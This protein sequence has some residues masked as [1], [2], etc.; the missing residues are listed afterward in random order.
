MLQ[1][2]QVFHPEQDRIVSVRECA[3]AQVKFSHHV[4][5]AALL[6]PFFSGECN[7][8]RWLIGAR[9]PFYDWLKKF[10]FHLHLTAGVS[11]SA[12]FPA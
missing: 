7:L 4:K 8:F 12:L 5:P 1:V 6:V 11:V 9:C 10:A 3:R 2:G